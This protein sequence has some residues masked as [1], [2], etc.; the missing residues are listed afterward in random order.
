[1]ST[2]TSPIRVG[3]FLETSLVSQRLP[4]VSEEWLPRNDVAR[5]LERLAGLP[6]VE[7]RHGLNIDQTTVRDGLVFHGDLC[8]N[9]LDLYVWYAQIDRGPA[10]Y[11]IEALRALSLDTQVMI[12][13]SAFAV[14]VDKYSSHLR[15][16]RAGVR[17]ADSVLLHVDNVALAE[18]ILDGWGRAVLKPRRGFFG[19]GVLLIED[20]PT[21]RD[22][23]GYLA[24]QS[25]GLV[26]PTLMLERFYQHDPSDW[27]STT[28]INGSIMYGYRKRPALW[29]PM[30]NGALKVLDADAAGGGVDLCE[31][32]PAYAELALSA[33][34]ALGLEIVG[35][36]MILDDSGPLILDE[37]TYPGMYPELFA[38]S[39][40]DLGHELFRMIA[41][42]IERCR[43]SRASGSHP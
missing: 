23:A 8:L 41:E 40:K 1:M 14:G 29:S 37:N 4:R 11:H 35:F 13:P 19:K 12:E 31:V 34:K 2:Q 5:C 27:V 43:T 7:L 33:H 9:E 15:L 18:P 42:A 16:R 39:G 32:P 24:T 20:Y 22:V 36:D 28:I 26:E 10:S 30:R 21:L 38:A 25:P 6:D 3:T 17:A